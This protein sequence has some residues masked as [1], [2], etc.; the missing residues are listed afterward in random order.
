M[1]TSNVT[2][3]FTRDEFHEN[4]VTGE[5]WPGLNFYYG[6]R[7]Y[8]LGGFKLNVAEEFDEVMDDAHADGD[9]VFKMYMY[10]H[11]GC[12]VSLNEFSCQWDSGMVGFVIISAKDY[13]SEE[14][15]RKYAESFT[16]TL[17]SWLQN[18]IWM[19]G[20]ED[21][22]GEP[23]DTCGGFIG[24]DIQTNGMLEYIPEEYRELAIAEWENR[25]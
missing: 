14:D 15:A 5:E 9:W 22:D 3:K 25:E 11:S 6:H 13:P 19:F 23:I 20:I 2:I 12:T 24:D 16:S 1:T 8:D 21:A 10:D 4:P 17:D 7:R 18:D